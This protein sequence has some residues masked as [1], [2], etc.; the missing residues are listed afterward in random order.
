MFSWKIAQMHIIEPTNPHDDN[1][2]ELRN[3]CHLHLRVLVKIH[4][5]LLWQR[6][7]LVA[8]NKVNLFFSHLAVKVLVA[9]G[10]YDSSIAERVGL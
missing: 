10:R 4:V 2:L 6:P 5:R 9:Q 7:K 8:L 3:S 1:P